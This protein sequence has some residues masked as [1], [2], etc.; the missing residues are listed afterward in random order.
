MIPHHVVTGPE[1]APTLVLS[2]SLGTTLR[3]WDPQIDALAERFR[4]VRYDTRGH[5]ESDTPHGPYSIDE[6]GGPRRRHIGAR[7]HDPCAPTHRSS[8]AQL[9]HQALDRAARHAKAVTTQL[10]PHLFRAVDLLEVRRGGRILAL[11]PRHRTRSSSWLVS[12]SC[13]CASAREV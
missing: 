1:D 13:R 5:G 12:S 8:Q 10:S 3:M 6:V 9:A 11:E 2:N 4:V 7:G